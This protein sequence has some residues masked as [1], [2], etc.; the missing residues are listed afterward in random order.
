MH[1]ISHVVVTAN[2]ARK[3]RLAILYLLCSNILFQILFF[4]ISNK[5]FLFI[6]NLLQIQLQ[7]CS[8]KSIFWSSIKSIVSEFKIKLKKRS[9]NKHSSWYSYIAHSLKIVTESNICTFGMCI[10]G[11]NND[12]IDRYE[13]PLYANRFFMWLIHKPHSRVTAI[14]DIE[15]SCVIL[16]TAPLTSVRNLISR[17]KKEIK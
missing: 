13:M 2:T 11:S 1:S 4:N 14:Y 6:H 8:Y 15:M 7:K 10:S 17:K 9:V 3:V 16:Q 12:L 5:I